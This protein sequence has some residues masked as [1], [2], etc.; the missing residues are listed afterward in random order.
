MAKNNSS[1]PEQRKQE[2]VG[3]FSRSSPTYDRVGPRFFTSFGRRL[4]ELAQIPVS[5]KVLDVATGRGAVLFASAEAI[6]ATGHAV[7]IDLAEGMV[8]ETTEEIRRLNLLNVEVHQM[9]AEH[10]QFPDEFFDCVTCGFAVFFFPDLDRAL[11]EFRRVLKPNARLAITSWDFSVDD[12][13][14]K[15]L[16]KLIKEY[17]PPEEEKKESAETKNPTK[18]DLLSPGGIEGLLNSKGFKT[19]HLSSESGKFVY[20]SEDEWWATQWAHGGRSEL[21]KIEE[22]HGSDG[23]ERFKA[24]VFNGLKEIKQTDGIHDISQ[25]I[26]AVA[27][28]K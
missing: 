19:V 17:L 4:V 25:V 1:D 15:W 27:I 21:E 26:Y 24:A 22:K 23:L 28:K 14:W 7:G 6:G 20:S 8:R 3:V 13:Q 9:D 11:A 2:I 10:L 5:A 16:D 12:E 18:P